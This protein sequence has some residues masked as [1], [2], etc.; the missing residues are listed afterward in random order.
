MNT[1]FLGSEGFAVEKLGLNGNRYSKEQEDYKFL[2]LEKTKEY[3][4]F[5]S[6]KHKI[7]Y[8]KGD[9]IISKIDSNHIVLFIN[10]K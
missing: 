1:G 2:N 8:N 3:L 6:E 5:N 7:D 10:E 9:T 4:F